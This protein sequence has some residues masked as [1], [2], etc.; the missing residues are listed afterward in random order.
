MSLS[1]ITSKQNTEKKQNYVIWINKFFESIKTDDIYK[2]IAENVK[3]RLYTSNYELD[4]PLM[5]GKYKKVIEL[6]K[7]ELG[8]KTMNEYSK[9]TAKSYSYLKDDSI[10]DRKWN[11]TKSCRKNKT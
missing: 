10:E 4:R 9:L 6:I 7:D 11:R 2:E 8:G 1:I 3:T 5:K